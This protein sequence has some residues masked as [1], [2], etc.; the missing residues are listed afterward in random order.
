MTI[1]EALENPSQGVI[2]LPR[3]LMCPQ[4]REVDA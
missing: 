1:H 2:K 3:D 4:P